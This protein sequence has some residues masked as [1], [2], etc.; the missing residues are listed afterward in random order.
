M[1]LYVPR[2]TSRRIAMSAISIVFYFVI[3]LEL[4]TGGG[5]SRALRKDVLLTNPHNN[6]IIMLNGLLSNDKG[7]T[8]RAYLYQLVYQCG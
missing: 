8:G 3:I 5:L 2:G 6:I 1:H 4:P 7:P